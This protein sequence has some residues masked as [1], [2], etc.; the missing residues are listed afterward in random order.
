MCSWSHVLPRGVGDLDGSG[1]A[2]S[3][4][5]SAREHPSLAGRGAIA[6]GLR[7]RSWVVVR[8]D[9]HSWDSR[10]QRRT[11]SGQSVCVNVPWELQIVCPGNPRAGGTNVP[12]D[13]A[14]PIHRVIRPASMVSGSG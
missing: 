10:I 3:R 8:E 7:S 12:S 9:I 13:S 6:R 11:H 14:P 4:S 2:S 1:E 5:R